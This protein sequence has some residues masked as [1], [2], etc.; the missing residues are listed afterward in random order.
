VVVTHEVAFARAV[1][2]EVIFMDAGEV[3]ER[4]PPA[5]VIDA[6]THERAV[7]FFRR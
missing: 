1:A 6:P 4:G 3:V 5:H 7:R 2:H